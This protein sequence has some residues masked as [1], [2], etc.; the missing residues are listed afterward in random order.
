M[1]QCQ[2]SLT[3][4]CA[5]R[6]SEATFIIKPRLNERFLACAGDAI[7]SNLSHRQRE[8]VATRVT[9]SSEFDDLAT[10]NKHGRRPFGQ[11]IV[12]ST[13][14]IPLLDDKKQTKE[15]EKKRSTWVR[16]WLAR[17]K[18][19]GFSNSDGTDFKG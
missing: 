10:I 19:R 3:L 14:C 12:L 16:P 1:F 9:N 11:G 2:L 6:V 7:F 15:E 17:R 8:R 4:H 13:I 18:E 5:N